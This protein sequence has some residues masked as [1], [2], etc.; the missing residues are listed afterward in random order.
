MRHRSMQTM[1]KISGGGAPGLIREV[2]EREG[3]RRTLCAGLSW[4]KHSEEELATIARCVGGPG[5]AVILG[6]LARDRKHWRS[7]LPDLV[8]WKTEPRPAAR[9]VEVKGPRDALADHQRA[10]LAELAF[11]GIDVEICKI[12]E[13]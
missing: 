11:G 2:W 8:M 3:E 4:D 13:P 6:L 12:V 5:L 7:G 10:W 1:N 9:L